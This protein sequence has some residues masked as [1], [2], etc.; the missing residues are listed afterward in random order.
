MTFK[1]SHSSN[2]KHL[3]LQFVELVSRY[4]PSEFSAGIL[5]FCINSS[6]PDGLLGVRLA[7]W[8]PSRKTTTRVIKDPRNVSP[9]PE[10]CK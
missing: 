1:R 2:G 7:E 8:R 3:P 4:V 5:S 9:P 6:L 10:L